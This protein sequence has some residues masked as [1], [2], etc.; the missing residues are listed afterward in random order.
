MSEETNSV[1]ADIITR[2]RA[3]QF[4]RRQAMQTRYFE[5]FGVVVCKV[6]YNRDTGIWM[7]QDARTKPPFTYDNLD[8][9]AVA[10]YD[11]LTE[12]KAVF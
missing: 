2:L 7:L 3:M 1:L 12:F 9:V 6:T 10:I 11:A 8:M 4:D 5:Q